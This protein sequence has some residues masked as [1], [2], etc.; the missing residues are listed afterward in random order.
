[1]WKKCRLADLFPLRVYF[2]LRDEEILREILVRFSCPQLTWRQSKIIEVYME[3]KKRKREPNETD[4]DLVMKERKGEILSW[5][6]EFV[7][8][9][10]DDPRIRFLFKSVNGEVYG[11]TLP[12]ST[13]CWILANAIKHFYRELHP[14][15]E[16]VPTTPPYC[17]H[18][19]RKMTL[20]YTDE[21]GS[22]WMCPDGITMWLPVRPEEVVE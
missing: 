1:M 15:M 5:S 7:E 16:Y 17:P 3:V 4:S 10:E 14:V 21:S 6:P 20:V 19:G 9:Y 2:A 8:Y 18:C 11:R 12:A 22:Q 13:V